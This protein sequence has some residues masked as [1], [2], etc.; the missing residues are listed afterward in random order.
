MTAVAE[1]APAKACA[2]CG[3]AFPPDTDRSAGAAACAA[4]GVQTTDP[5]PSD[6]DLA[7]AYA[8]WYRPDSGRFT[9]PLDRVLSWSR[10]RLAHRLDE[11][12]PEGP[13]LDVGS[14]P[15]VLL[16]ELGALGRPATGLERQST[17]PDVLEAEVGDVTGDWAGVVFWHSLEHLPAPRVALEEATALL[18]PDGVLVLAVPNTE[19]LQ[20]RAFGGK[21][22]AR[23]YPRHLVHIPRASLL[24]TLTSL[25]LKPSRVSGWRGGQVLFG[26]LHGLVGA[27]PPHLSLYDAIRRPEA[28]ERALSPAARLLALVIAVPALPVAALMTVIEIVLG[29]GGT[30]YVEAFRV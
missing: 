28:R 22:F 19:S 30:T 15:G 12:A 23:D 3:A 24:A 26:W 10:R 16:D 18:V 20:A 25:G 29:R 21:W 8:D 13:I 7:A 9:G 6:A 14:G 17:R 4:C 2:W 5:W 27:V 11:I 1:T